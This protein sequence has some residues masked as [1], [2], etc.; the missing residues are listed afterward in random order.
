METSLGKRIVKLRKS[1]NITQSELAKKVGVSPMSVCRW[2]RNL[3][4]PTGIHLIRLGNLAHEDAESCW[5]FW[6]LAGLT[7]SD[8]VRVLPIAEERLR[9]TVPILQIVKRGTKL[10]EDSLVAIPFLG[11]VAVAG[12]GEG[13][14]NS[15][16]TKARTEH[17]I[18]APRLWCPNPTR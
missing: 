2:E 5:D 3:G 12:K 11:A 16:L 1:L 14:S 4:A 15:H 8:V 17:I 13:S 6:N 7:V 10:T 9:R 18:A